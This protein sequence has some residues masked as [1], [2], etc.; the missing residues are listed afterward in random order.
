MSFVEGSTGCGDMHVQDQGN[1]CYVIHLVRPACAT[2]AVFGM[3]LY[4]TGPTCRKLTLQP[5]A[6]TECIFKNE[7]PFLDTVCRTS[8]VS[9]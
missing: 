8:E 2:S 1:F 7:K 5:Y 4:Y 6:M 3:L 9:P